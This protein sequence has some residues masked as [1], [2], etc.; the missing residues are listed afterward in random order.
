[1]TEKLATYNDIHTLQAD[2]ENI[3]DETK[4]ELSQADLDEALE[5]DDSFIGFD[6]AAFQKVFS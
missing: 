5:D 1:M 2:L 3:F 6:E 4:E